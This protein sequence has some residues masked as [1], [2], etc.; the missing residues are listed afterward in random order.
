M[1]K[2]VSNRFLWFW[3]KG[4]LYIAIASLIHFFWLISDNVGILDWIKEIAN[5]L[6]D[7]EYLSKLKKEVKDY[8]D[9]RNA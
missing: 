8:K 5:A 7:K 4:Y 3:E 9:E 1:S 6:T 2:S